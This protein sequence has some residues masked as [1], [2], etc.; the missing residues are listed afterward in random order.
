MDN[1]S[2]NSNIINIQNN[3]Q[4]S[5][6]SRIGRLQENLI[7]MG[8]DIIMINKVI[9]NFNIQTESEALDYMVKN[10]DGLWNHPFIP[11]EINEDELNFNDK[12]L[13]PPKII[14]NK[15][16]SKIKTPEDNY[17]K[18]NNSKNVN[19]KDNN[20]NLRLNMNI[21]E[22]CGELREFHKIKNY[23]KNN[24]VDNKNENENE[25]ENENNNNYLNKNL[26]VFDDNLKEEKNI[27]IDDDEEDKK[28]IGPN[29]NNQNLIFLNDNEEGNNENINQNE[30]LICM[31]ELDNPVIIEKCKHKF[32]YEC[33]NLYLVNLIN[34][35]NIDKI[36]CPKNSCPNKELSESFFCQY[37][38]SYDYSKYLKFKKQNIIARDPKKIF[39]PHCDSYAQIQGEIYESSNPNYKKTTLKCM[40]NHEFCSCGRP[41]HEK[42]CYKEE[43]EFQE[44][45][46]KEKIKKC[47]KCGFLIKKTWGCNHMTCGNPACKHQF[48]WLCMK[49]YTYDHYTYGE[50][51]GKQF[52]DPETFEYWL[53]ENCPY[54]RYIYLGFLIFLLFIFLIISYIFVPFIG[55]CLIAFILL[56]D[57]EISL[58]FF[59]NNGLK[60]S[61]VKLI[62]FLTYDC[63]SLPCQS[64]IY[65]FYV[66]AFIILMIFLTI[67]IPSLFIYILLAIIKFLFECNSYNFDNE[68]NLDGI[69]LSNKMNDNNNNII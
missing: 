10:K 32:C 38:S 7:M 8:F 55:L 35:N 39:C 54:L 19:N 42:D 4:V 36:P 62:L 21:C 22:I 41:L 66:I 5:N 53:H 3:S 51:E 12:I 50:C 18:R 43:K 56:Y 44:Y 67:L 25:N 14:M 2:I 45:L 48:C 47:P 30:C 16:L 46:K 31:G 61:Y 29:N 9:S 58:S 65:I 64:I 69:E 17:S 11:K 24:N 15:V 6:N 27:L 33:F 59:K 52:L 1:N 37:L 57:D 28:Y 26:F 34:N 63:L 23:V 40:N 60:N 68:I 13:N 20:K 49:E